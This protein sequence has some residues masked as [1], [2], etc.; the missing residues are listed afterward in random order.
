MK[1]PGVEEVV[2]EPDPVAEQ[3][4]LRERARRVDR[5]DADLAP[6]G[7]HEA[8]ERRDEA[9]LA[10][11]GRPGDPDGVR[12]ARLRVDVADDLV[13]E[14]V[15]VLDERDRARERAP[16]AGAERVDERSRVHSRR[17]ATAGC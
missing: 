11:A 2:G 7:A 8:D 10:D 13:G 5:D 9:R 3:R 6:V 1:T 17:P 16:V 12:T 4:A 14:R 15:A